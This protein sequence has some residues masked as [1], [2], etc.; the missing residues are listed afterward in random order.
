MQKLYLRLNMAG[1]LHP[2]KAL[3][4]ILLFF[5]IFVF[6]FAQGQGS[7]S[8]APSQR[9]IPKRVLITLYGTITDS[10]SGQPLAGASIY[11]TEAR[12]GDIADANGHYHLS[13]IPA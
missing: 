11:I 5:S 4:T 13:N 6:A 3:N 12:V 9:M 10:V 1:M 8:S 2:K 7:K